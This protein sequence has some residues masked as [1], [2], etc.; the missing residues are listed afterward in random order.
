MRISTKGRYALRMMVYLAQNKNKGYISLKEISDNEG[1]SKKYLEQIVQIFNKAGYL[2]VI[3]GNKGGYSLAKKPKEYIVGDIIRK[4]EGK[5]FVVECVDSGDCKRNLDCPTHPVW[6]NLSKIINDYL[7][8]IT[9]EDFIN[10]GN[11]K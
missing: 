7:D 3:R 6:K 4:T 1:I 11:I 5:L 2:N 9:L 8:K 10:K